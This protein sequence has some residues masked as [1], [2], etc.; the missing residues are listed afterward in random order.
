[1]LKSNTKSLNKNRTLLFRLITFIIPFAFFILLEAS[2]RLFGYGASLPLFIE[3]PDSENYLLARPDIIKRYFPNSNNIPSVTIEANLF[4]KEKPKNGIRLF[5]QGGSTAAGFP[6]GFGASPAG[7]LDQ[8][9]SKTFPHHQVEVINTAMSAISSYTLLDFVDEIIEQKPDA[10]LIYAGHNEFLGILGVGSNYTTASSHAANLIFLKLKDFRV[11]QLIQN[12]YAFFNNRSDMNGDS[13]SQL[14]KL[15]QKNK[16]TMMAKVAKNK[17]IEKG[18]DIY[19]NGLNQFED[20]LSLILA[21]YQSAKIP[22][23]ISTIASNLKDHPP[24]SSFDTNRSS[25]QLLIKIE[26]SLKSGESLSHHKKELD[27]L[28]KDAKLN[29]D[30]FLY[31]KIAK[32]YEWSKKANKA[33]SF[34]LKAKDNDLL[35]FRA[36]EDINIIITQLAKQY[37]ATLVDYEENLTLRSSSKIIGDNFMLEHLHPN[38]QGYFIL[39]DSFYQKLKSN[40][41]FGKWDKAITTAKA[42]QERPIIPA[43]EY[44][45][46]A[47]IIKLKSD[48]PYTKQPKKIVLP[49]PLDWQQQLGLK[50]YS[51]QISWLEML[52]LSYKGYLDRRN[53][54]M[55]LKTS[56]MIADAMP[57][58]AEINFRVGKQ[59]LQEKN[60]LKAK[61]YFQRS[62]MEDPTNETYRRFLEKNN[63]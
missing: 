23:F 28:I 21:K 43:E 54:S 2:L 25:K 19:L 30:A 3:T 63:K 50:Y 47:K 6:Y 22:V 18:S 46:F 56:E 24:F 31:Y 8:R 10:V 61:Q 26:R 4:L 13:I 33:K 52:N 5:V 38:L 29:N 58:N 37:A 57:Q 36:P 27:N 14:K 7:M 42:W 9:L 59:Q 39:A 34:Y 12:S 55:V 40:Q 20:N 48:Y 32:L 41:L 15:T 45:A 16:R 11:Y 35:R 51:K 53:V 60:L 49:K 1:M 44:A 17:S 62:L